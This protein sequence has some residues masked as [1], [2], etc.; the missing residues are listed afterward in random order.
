MA[1]ELSVSALLGYLIGNIIPAALLDKIKKAGLRKKGT[2]NLGATNTLLVLGK[3]W[4]VLVLI[5]DMLKAFFAVYLAQWIFPLQPLSGMVS[6]TCAVLGHVF[7]FYMGFRGGKGLAAFGGLVL[8]VDWRL[9]LLLLGVDAVLVLLTDVWVVTPFFAGIFFPLLYGIFFHDLWGALVA[10]L[11]GAV[12]IYKNVE[13]LRRALRGED[14]SV[15]QT[16][17]KK[18]E[19]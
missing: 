17:F 8:A 11:A 5:F 19:K 7:P 13:G 16:L 4:G 12:L 6:G 10:A 1:L 3:K 2:R 14:K 9:F 15:R 18:R